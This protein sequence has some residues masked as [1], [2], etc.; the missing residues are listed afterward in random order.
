MKRSWGIGIA[1]ASAL[2]L[3]GCGVSSLS[4]SAPPVTA[5][6]AASSLKIV[7]LTIQPTEACCATLSS[8]QMA[9]V[10]AQMPGVL[11]AGSLSST[12]FNVEYNPKKTSLH[13]LEHDI[14]TATG[15]QANA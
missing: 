14:L 12:V 13:K 1:A 15:Y 6:A 9:Q 4:A 8:G 3:T 5:A 10:L 11:K 7:K 2:A